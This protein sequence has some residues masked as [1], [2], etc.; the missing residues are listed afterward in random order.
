MNFVWAWRFKTSVHWFLFIPI[1]FFNKLNYR[2]MHLNS[3]IVNT[4]TGDLG[5]MGTWHNIGESFLPLSPS[6]FKKST[7]RSPGSLIIT[8]RLCSKGSWRRNLAK[9]KEQKFTW[10]TT[11]FLG[12]QYSGFTE[13]LRSTSLWAAKK[14]SLLSYFSFLSVKLNEGT[15]HLRNLF[16]FTVLKCKFL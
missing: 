13:S 6:N 4:C 2:S 1:F 7:C 12:F 5:M 11:F 15:T 8:R 10:I 9:K 16:N 14:H 3:S